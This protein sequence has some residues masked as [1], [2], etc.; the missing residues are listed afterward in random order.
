MM[1]FIKNEETARF[2]PELI[3][4]Y[5]QLIKLKKVGVDMEAVIFNGFQ[6][7]ICKLLQ[8][9]CSQHLHQRDEKAFDSSHQKCSIADYN[10]AS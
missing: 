5:R 1:H 7:A 6:S 10:K 9:Y 3:S 2:C 8:M 4:A